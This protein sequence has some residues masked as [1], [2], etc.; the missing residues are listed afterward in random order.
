[1]SIQNV[2][3]IASSRFAGVPPASPLISWNPADTYTYGIDLSNDDRTM[4]RN[5]TPAFAYWSSG[6][7]NSGLGVGLLYW[8]CS[9]D[10]LTSSY[11]GAGLSI[12]GK[13]LIGYVGDDAGSLGFISDGSRFTGGSATTTLSAFSNGD[14]LCMA[15]DLTHNKVW[16][17]KNNGAWN[18]AVGGTQDPATNAGGISLPAGLIGVDLYPTGSVQKNSSDKITGRFNIAHFSF[19]VPAGFSAWDTANTIVAWNSQDMNVAGSGRDTV[20][21]ENNMKA[22]QQGS[23]GWSSVRANLLRSSGKYYFEVV[24]STTGT[25]EC[26]VGVM[27]TS[28]VLSNYIG[29]SGTSI[30]VFYN[31]GLF[32]N[33]TNPYTPISAISSGD[34]VSVAADFAAGRLWFRKNALDWQDNLG[35][36]YGPVSGT[37]GS[38]FTLSAGVCPA[39]SVKNSNSFVRG[40][41]KASEFTQSVP[42]GY[43]PWEP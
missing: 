23:G 29:S 7:A 33:G 12:A 17:R 31:G 39:A 25:L 11:V 24:F 35:S 28:A 42:T 20:L 26:E 37:G 15:L 22:S 34:V 21:T 32:I 8:E 9:F 40:R 27:Q 3:I 10:V 2:G 13:S 18:S 14:V 16:V 36:G 41:F 1:M 30:G 38:A 4:F 5:N 43:L 6:R 19:P